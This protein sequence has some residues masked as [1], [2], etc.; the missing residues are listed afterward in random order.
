MNYLNRELFFYFWL[1]ISY[2]DNV[3]TQNKYIVSISMD[4]LFK[5]VFEKYISIILRPKK[6]KYCATQLYL[7]LVEICSVYI[8][9]Y[10][11]Y[12]WIKAEIT[13]FLFQS[14]LICYFINM[15]IPLFE[16]SRF[17]ILLFF[18][19]ME[20]LLDFAWPGKCRASYSLVYIFF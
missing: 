3:Y 6:K 17:I 12:L 18:D 8:F 10:L 16:S 1:K 7:L 9:I 13:F 11:H 4:A 14:L 20:P 19:K 2:Y 5:I 15:F